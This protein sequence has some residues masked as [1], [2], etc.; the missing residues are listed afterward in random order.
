MNCGGGSLQLKSV[1]Q[2]K[3]SNN[4]CIFFEVNYSHF[5]GLCSVGLAYLRL[6]LY[7]RHFQTIF[8]SEFPSSGSGVRWKIILPQGVFV[9]ISHPFVPRQVTVNGLKVVTGSRY[10]YRGKSTKLEGNEER[11]VVS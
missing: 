5:H 2:S 8:I 9:S 1:K 7:P 4:I 11:L 3:A 6:T 10:F